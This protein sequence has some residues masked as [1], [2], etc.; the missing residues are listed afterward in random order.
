MKPGLIT[1]CL[2]KRTLPQICQWAAECYESLEMAAWP[3]PGDR[4]FT[5]TH[6]PSSVG[7]G[8]SSRVAAPGKS[9]RR[10]P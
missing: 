4:P 5:A 7:D 1:A 2:P 3:N 6:P 9:D 8:L 10:L